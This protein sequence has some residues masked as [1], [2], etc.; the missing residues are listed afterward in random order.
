M[1]IFQSFL[2]ASIQGGAGQ[3]YAQQHENSDFQSF[4]IASYGLVL[5]GLREKSLNT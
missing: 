4:L 5:N 1:I 3:S 2:I